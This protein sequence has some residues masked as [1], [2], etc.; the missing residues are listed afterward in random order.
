[1]K[2]KRKVGQPIGK[3]YFF[4]RESIFSRRVH[5]FL[6]YT[7]G[8]INQW[9]DRKFKKVSHIEKKSSKEMDASFSGF[10]TSFS[11]EDV[12]LQWVICASRFDWTISDQGTLIHEVVHTIVKIWDHNHIPVD[13][14]TQEF[15]AHSIGNLYEDIAAKIFRVK[16]VKSV[17]KK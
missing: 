6:N 11:G 16:K 14:S 10:S 7:N 2:R 8:E 1:M 5:V 17:R 9:F 12:P 13:A 15:L 4:V 3:R